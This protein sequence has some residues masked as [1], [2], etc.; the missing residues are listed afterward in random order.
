MPSTVD[1]SEEDFY[2][3]RDAWKLW[4]SVGHYDSGGA[5]VPPV[6]FQEAA[7]MPR[8]MLDVFQGLDHY[9]SQMQKHQAKKQGKKPRGT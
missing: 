5:W 6:S 8:V 2:R 9:L 7:E 1:F 4:R 3:Y